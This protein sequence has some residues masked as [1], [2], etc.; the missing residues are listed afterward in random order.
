MKLIDID[1]IEE[2][3]S[4]VHYIKIYKASV[5]L[6]DK[7]ATLSRHDIDF[8]IEYRPVGAP[9]IKIKFDDHPHFATEELAENIKIKINE[10]EKK[11][12]LHAEH[13]KKK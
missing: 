9:F 3:E 11:G 12:D 10:M 7:K 13:R 5:I 4:H 6:M 8:T 2:K 1:K